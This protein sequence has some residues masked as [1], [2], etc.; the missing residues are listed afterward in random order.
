MFAITI[1]SLIGSTT[2]A[3]LVA[4]KNGTLFY[5]RTALASYKLIHTYAILV[6]LASYKLIH[7]T[8]TRKAGEAADSVNELL[9]PILKKKRKKSTTHAKHLIGRTS[10]VRYWD[11]TRSYSTVSLWSV[12]LHGSHYYATEHINCE[13]A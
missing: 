5:F 13:P 8:T 11:V 9:L 4:M 2:Y 7:T 10:D 12:A 3:V 1:E 6:A